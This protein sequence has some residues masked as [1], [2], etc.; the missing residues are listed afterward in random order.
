MFFCEKNP[1][2]RD[3]NSRPNV[4]EKC[5]LTS[6][7]EGGSNE[8][9]KIV[10][11]HRSVEFCEATP[12]NLVDE[13]KESLYG[14]ETDRDLRSACRCV[15][16]FIFIFSERAAWGVGGV[17]AARLFILFSFPSSADHERDWPLLLLLL[18][19]N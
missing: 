19:S 4:S 9:G 12:F 15:S 18:S 10:I 8:T 1:S 6:P 5:G 7:G 14:R 17:C 2:Y 13:S 11:A 3:L 16:I